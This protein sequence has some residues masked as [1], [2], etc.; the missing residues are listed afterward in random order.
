MNEAADKDGQ[1]KYI[2]PGLFDNFQTILNFFLFHEL[3]TTRRKIEKKKRKT[4]ITSIKNISVPTG[5]LL[6]P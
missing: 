1:Q 3:Y 5:V 6:I 2:R 4:K